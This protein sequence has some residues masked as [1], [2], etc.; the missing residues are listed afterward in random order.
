VNRQQPTG[1]F[2]AREAAVFEESLRIHQESDS[3]PA[4]A[5]AASFGKTIG[6]KRLFTFLV[7]GV[8]FVFTR[9]TLITFS[10]SLHFDRKVKNWL[11]NTAAA[12]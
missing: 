1:P 4:R 5:V 10:R 6:A 11:A 8:G 7:L 9:V 2:P 12:I 3:P